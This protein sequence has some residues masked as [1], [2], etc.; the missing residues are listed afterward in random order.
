MCEPKLSGRITLQTRSAITDCLMCVCV[1]LK[2]ERERVGEREHYIDGKRFLS[3]NF[4]SRLFLYLAA[5]NT[6]VEFKLVV[7]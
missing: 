5:N 7:M 2:R 1:C 4:V 3:R 6:G